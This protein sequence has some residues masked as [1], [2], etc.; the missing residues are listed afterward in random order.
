MKMLCWETTLVATQL[1]RNI[2]K[3]N[4]F[5]GYLIII[6]SEIYISVSD[7]L[8]MKTPVKRAF[9]PQQE[10]QSPLTGKKRSQWSERLVNRGYE[11]IVADVYCTSQKSLV[12]R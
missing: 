3:R 6:I 9:L 8:N 2:K 10:C 4:F 12:L 11:K 5:I 1:R 7:L